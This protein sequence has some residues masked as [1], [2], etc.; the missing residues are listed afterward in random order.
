MKS[1]SKVKHIYFLGIGGIGMSALARYFKYFGFKV[2]GYDKTPTVLTDELAREGI[3]VYFDEDIKNI[4]KDTGLVVYTPAIPQTHRQFVYFREN[5]FDMMK[6]AEVLGLISENE[7]SV[8]VA[9]T[10]GKTTITSL[11]SHILI[12]AAIPVTAFIG[13]ISKNYNTNL[14]INKKSRFM[15]VE[16]DEYDRSFLKLK[17]DI[18]V[19]SA[20][21]ADHLDVYL[22]KKHLSDSFDLFINQIKDNGT[23]I[24]KNGL[25]LI[26]KNNAFTYH[27]KE[28][29]DFYASDITISKGRYTFNVCGTTNINKIT[30]GLPGLHNIENSLAAIAVA[31]TLGIENDVIKNA[32][33]SFSGVKRRFEY[34][35]NTNKFTFI[36]DY[37]HHPEEIRACISSVRE[38]FPGK[39]ITGIFQPHLFSRTRDFM[40]E[41]ALSL[42]LL[43][44]LLLLDIYPARE[45]PVEGI[46]SEVLLDKINMKSKQLVHMNEIINKLDSNKTEVLLTMGAGD[47]DQLIE[48]IRQYYLKKL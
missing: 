47:I 44:D 18:A 31:K 38:L 1:Y 42:A 35:I 7:K 15:I 5:H 19:I 16:A 11:I 21:D 23:L 10:H 30:L 29:C 6:R 9:G 28:K 46:N 43:D 33:Y 20:I 2:S 3:V 8:A 26:P 22:E 40:N 13:G 27:L 36:D 4:P 37:A 39:K 25:S 14:I 24:F 12:Q 48:P 32:L 17:P 41:F 45:L 34:I